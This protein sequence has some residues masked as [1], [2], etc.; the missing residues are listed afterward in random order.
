MLMAAGIGRRAV[1]VIG[2]KGVMEY[3]E[4]ASTGPAG[5]DDSRVF[6]SIELWLPLAADANERYRWGYGGPG[7]ERLI[8]AALP[9]LER[10]DSSDAARAVLWFCHQRQ[11]NVE[12]RR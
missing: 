7:I 12:A 9:D 5:A 1:V 11:C 10:A 8:L 2:R 6:R 4:R 3:D